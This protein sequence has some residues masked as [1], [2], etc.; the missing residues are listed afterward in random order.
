MPLTSRSVCRLLRAMRSSQASAKENPL[1]TACEVPEAN[2]ALRV[3][4]GTPVVQ[5]SALSQS[6]SMVPV[7]NVS[8]P[9][10]ASADGL[11]IRLTS[12][13]LANDIKVWICIGWIPE[14][15]PANRYAE[16]RRD[17]SS[18]RSKWRLYPVAYPSNGQ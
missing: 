11:S 15:L 14:E 16:P 6:L 9:V 5:L 3:L 12:I 2:T 8:P 18:G 10:Q 17:P 13:A 1:T 7:Q 4:E